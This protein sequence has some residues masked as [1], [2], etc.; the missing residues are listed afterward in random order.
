MAPVTENTRW[1]L[2]GERMHGLRHVF[3]ERHGYEVVGGAVVAGL[4]GVEVAVA[5]ADEGAVGG[6][7]ALG[8]C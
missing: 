8:G 6:A 2:D 5:A 7:G 1:V 4:A 3:H